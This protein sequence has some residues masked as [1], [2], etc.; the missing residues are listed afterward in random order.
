MVIFWGM[1]F[2]EFFLN[3]E[4]ILVDVT[5]YHRGFHG[6]LNE[7]LLIGNV[8]EQARKLTQNTWECLQKAIEI[9]EAKFTKISCV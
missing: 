5:V 8:S 3:F 7:T 9:G 2:R 4:T 1:F 6:D